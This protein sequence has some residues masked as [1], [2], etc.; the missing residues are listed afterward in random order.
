MAEKT[1][2][3]NI[4]SMVKL[5]EESGMPAM[6]KDIRLAK[7]RTEDILKSLSEKTRVFEE[8]ERTAAL[9]QQRLQKEAEAAEKAKAAA[10]AEK[11]AA[12]KAQK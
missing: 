1:V 8:A 9:E 12:E 2:I 3:N 10:E 5:R 7:K 6:L 11:A 4:K